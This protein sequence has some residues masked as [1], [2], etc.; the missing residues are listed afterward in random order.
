[1]LL[2][3]SNIAW[4]VG[5]YV[6]STAATHA[7]CAQ[8]VGLVEERDRR[9]GDKAQLPEVARGPR[10]LLAEAHIRQRAGRDARQRRQTERLRY[11]AIACQ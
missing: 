5:F 4:T 7:Q 2:S 1:M 11:A 9:R 3:G 8:P 10:A 6:T